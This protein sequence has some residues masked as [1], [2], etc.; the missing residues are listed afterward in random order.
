MESNLIFMPIYSD[1]SLKYVMVLALPPPILP[2]LALQ[3][4]ND[5]YGQ[6][7]TTIYCGAAYGW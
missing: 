1:S 4:G 6:R 2:P 7:A 3:H 5:F